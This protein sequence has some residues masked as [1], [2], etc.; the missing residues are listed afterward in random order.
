MKKILLLSFAILAMAA[1]N[2]DKNVPVE[3]IVLSTSSATF[4]TSSMDSIKM[5]VGDTL[6]LYATIF[7]HNATDK[8]LTWIFIGRDSLVSIDGVYL[9]NWFDFIAG[10]E[11][12][13][14]AVKTTTSKAF[15]KAVGVSNSQI[16]V[17]SEQNMENTITAVHVIVDTLR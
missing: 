9:K 5:I 14:N 11:I 7:P 4:S 1:C 3:H 10:R 16:G 12:D 17:W 15:I 6:T 13:S 8:S 2:K